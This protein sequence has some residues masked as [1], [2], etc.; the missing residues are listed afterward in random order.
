MTDQIDW[1]KILKNED[2]LIENSDRKHRYHFKSL[3]ERGTPVL[4]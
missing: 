2:K 3:H 4:G 1:N